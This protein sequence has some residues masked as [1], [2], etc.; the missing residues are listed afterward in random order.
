MTVFSGEEA[1][2]TFLAEFDGWLSESVDVYLL[3]GSAMT[4]R[5][6]KDQTED[7]DLALGVPTEF[8]HVYHALREQGFQVTGEPTASFEGVG[9]TVE[10]YH[11]DRGFRVDLFEQQVVGKVWITESMHDRADEFWTGEYATAYVLADEDLFLLKAV[12]GGD[13]GAG[14]RRDIEDMRTY[15]QRGLAYEEILNE[16]EEQRPFNTGSIEATH[17]RNQ[18]HPLF[19]IEVAVQSLSGLP[20]SFTDRVSE[21]A[22]EFEVEYGILEA[23]DE[24]FRS[25][26]AISERVLSN[27]RELS[28]GDEEAVSAGIDRLVEKEILDREGDTVHPSSN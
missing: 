11:P 18:S 25:P 14:R 22:T 15:A 12:S 10:L 4:V 5:G 27:V 1:I 9:K 7:I 19:T 21:F 20:S 13:L 16:I 6:L 3:G 17:I 26:R 24:G 23:V 2:K 8:E 28:V